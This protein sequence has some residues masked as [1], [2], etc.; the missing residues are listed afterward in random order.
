MMSK[1]DDLIAKYCPNGVEYKTLGEM[2]DIKTGNGITKKDAVEDGKYPIISGGVDPMGYYSQYNREANTV[3]ISRAGTAGYVN[4]ITTK[5]WVNDK[6]FS[7]IPIEQYKNVVNSKYLFFYLKNKEEQI[8]ALKS[9]GSVP[10][11]NIQKLSKIAI[12]VPPLAV[13]EEIVNILD[14]FTLLEAELEAELEA[15][16]KQYEHYR[17]NL[18]NFADISRGG[19]RI[20]ALCE[21]CDIKGRIGFR[22]YTRQ[23]QV[24]KG[25]GAISLSPANIIREQIDYTDCTYISWDKYYESP[26]I[27]AEVGD[28][29]FCK[30]AS[31]GKTA[32]I[33]FLPEKSTINPQLVL[34]KNIQCNASYLSY[35]LKTE[36]FQNQVKKITGLGSIPTVS[37]QN[38]SLLKIPIPPLAEQERIVSILDKFDELVNDISDGLP[39]EINARRQQYEYYRDK[40][41]NFEPMAA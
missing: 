11:V 18:L 9:T 8:I 28:I 14:S 20:M 36:Y 16:K 5:F 22:G 7:V 17:D 25:K 32:I 2:F 34:L 4:Y 24:A 10:T 31:V 23:D 35:V 37:Q 15:R 33:K 26:E 41:L 3:T 12:A 29:I 19:V 39:A 30:T 13:Q 38:F 27:M 6:C 21:V 1:I 40:L